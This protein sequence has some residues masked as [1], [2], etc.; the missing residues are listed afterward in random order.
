MK[1]SKIKFI[2]ALALA[3]LMASCGSLDKM[4]EAAKAYDFER[5]AQIRDIIL[6]I[7]AGI[8]K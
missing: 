6:E 5:A 2:G 7:K 8:G 4:K 3:A 1:Q